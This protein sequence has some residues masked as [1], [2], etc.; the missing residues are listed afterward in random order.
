[1]NSIYRTN[2]ISGLYMGLCPTVL[3]AFLVQ[4]LSYSPFYQR[5]KD[6]VTKTSQD[7]LADS[8]LFISCVLVPWPF[9]TI[10]VRLQMDSD[11]MKPLYK[12]TVDCVRKTVMNEGY[13]GLY[14]GFRMTIP[15]HVIC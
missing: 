15:Y 4:F 12:G 6:A 3:A 14:R 13:T 1:M 7:F 11:R 8:F 10:G 2:G 9:A 5:N